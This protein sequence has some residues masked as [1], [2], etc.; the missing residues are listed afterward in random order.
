[1]KVLRNL[2]CWLIA[3]DLARVTISE[4]KEMTTAIISRAERA[5]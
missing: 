3:P 1:M 2:E 4:M 5:K